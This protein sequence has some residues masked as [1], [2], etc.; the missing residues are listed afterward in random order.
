MATETRKAEE[1]FQESLPK[2]IRLDQTE[3]VKGT[4]QQEPLKRAEESSDTEK[5]RRNFQSWLK[6]Y[7]VLD[8]ETVHRSIADLLSLRNTASKSY[9][10]WHSEVLRLRDVQKNLISAVRL[11]KEAANSSEKNSLT[12]SLMDILRPHDKIEPRYFPG[13]REIESLADPEGKLAKEVV[14]KK[15]AEV[16]FKLIEKNLK[17]GSLTNNSNTVEILK[18]LEVLVRAYNLRTDDTYQYLLCVTV[19]QLFGFTI[20]GFI[21]KHELTKSELKSMK[22]TLTSCLLRFNSFSNVDRKQAYLLSIGLHC[23]DQTQSTVQHIID[24]LSG[25]L[26]MDL[27]QCTDDNLNLHVQKLYDTVSDLLKEFPGIET[28]CLVMSTLNQFH[29]LETVVEPEGAAEDDMAPDCE[30]SSLR[31][32]VKELLDLLGISSLLSSE[33][34]VSGCRK[35][36]VRCPQ[37]C[38]HF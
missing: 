38:G 10:Q 7:Q 18:S 28:E 37:Q 3:T 36:D 30:M 20:D 35:A 34:N 22:E 13:I 31:R 25:E 23:V 4:D 11:I 2:R 33:V 12:N 8:Q 1:E 5:L 26:C 19:F 21:F 9:E 24:R 16:L 15:T 17:Q 29:F 6:K 14:G 32:E 27:R